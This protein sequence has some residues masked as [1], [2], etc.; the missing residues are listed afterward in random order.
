M[1][2]SQGEVNAGGTESALPLEM[3]RERER[4]SDGLDCCYFLQIFLKT[5]V[6]LIEWNFF[7]NKQLIRT[8]FAEVALS[9]QVRMDLS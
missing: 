1:N 2:D 8:S 4:E 6:Q 7:S 9:S 5:V 3:D